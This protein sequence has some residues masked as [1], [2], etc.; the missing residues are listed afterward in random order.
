MQT[1]VNG[2]ADEPICILVKAGVVYMSK[3]RFWPR[4]NDFNRRLTYPKENFVKLS[5]FVFTGNMLYS[6]AGFNGGFARCLVEQSSSI[7]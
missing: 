3:S 7:T 2:G 5:R 4:S 1:I 6:G